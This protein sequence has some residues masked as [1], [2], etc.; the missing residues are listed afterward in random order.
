MGR[1]GPDTGT[2]SVTA[3]QDYVAESERHAAGFSRRDTNSL[4]THKSQT[5]NAAEM[6]PHVWVA[7]RAVTAQ[8][9]DPF[10]GAHVT[11]A[12]VKALHAQ[13]ELERYLVGEG[14]KRR[15]DFPQRRLVWGWRDAADLPHMVKYTA[16]VAQRQIAEAT[17]LTRGPDGQDLS[18]LVASAGPG[19]T[20]AFARHEPE[21][22][23]AA[24]SQAFSGARFLEHVAA[25]RS[26]LLLGRPSEETL[27][28]FT[29]MSAL[30]DADS[31]SEKDT[32]GAPADDGAPAPA[33]RPAAARAGAV[34]DR[35]GAGLGLGRPVSTV[36]VVPPAPA[37]QRRAGTLRVGL[38]RLETAAQRAPPPPPPPPPQSAFCAGAS[39]EKTFV[40]QVGGALAL[41]PLAESPR[42]GSPLAALPRVN[43][44]E[45]RTG[46]G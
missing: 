23:A 21:S 42:G 44:Y 20:R 45:R 9:A 14:S 25:V 12:N 10:T 35:P 43:L 41:S 31:W 26:T 37:W 18:A 4:L 36:L 13:Q 46:S 33:S 6:R 39:S 32:R 29:A 8:P 17:A 34:Q 27:A 3:G 38:S 16:D 40:T 30:A 11:V 24:P 2:S 5:G 19:W 7:L 22:A 28:S 15:A 1:R